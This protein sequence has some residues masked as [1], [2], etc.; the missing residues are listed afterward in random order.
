MIDLTSSLYLGL[1]HASTVVQPWASLTT[2]MPAALAE[3]PEAGMVAGGLADLMGRRP[4][5]WPR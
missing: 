1:H 2:G 5:S 3:A 4:R